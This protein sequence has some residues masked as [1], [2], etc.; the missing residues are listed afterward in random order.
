MV[1][2]TVLPLSLILMTSGLQLEIPTTHVSVVPTRRPT[3]LILVDHGIK[4][5][6]YQLVR[7]FVAALPRRHQV[8]HATPQQIKSR[9]RTTSIGPCMLHPS[10]VRQEKQMKKK[11]TRKCPQD[12]R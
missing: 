4:G 1:G 5:A 6:V 11:H 9:T 10:K 8:W 7:T 2:L 3:A 12:M